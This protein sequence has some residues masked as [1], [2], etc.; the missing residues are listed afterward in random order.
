M[1]DEKPLE[2]VDYGGGLWTFQRGHCDRGVGQVHR[3]AAG[4]WLALVWEPKTKRLGTSPGP[5]EAKRAVE[6]HLIEAGV[7][8]P[9]SD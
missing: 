2:W 1:T 7:Y 4:V 9:T 6:Q 3:V 8:E 5:E